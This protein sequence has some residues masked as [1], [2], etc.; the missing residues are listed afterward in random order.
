MEK[1]SREREKSGQP[2]VGSVQKLAKKWGEGRRGAT[3]VSLPNGRWRMQKGCCLFVAF[4]FASLSVATRTTL[5]LHR[6]ERTK[7]KNTKKLNLIQIELAAAHTEQ[8][9]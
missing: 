5:K 8:K 2:S 9:K 7:N 4:A 1:K 6:A 3:G